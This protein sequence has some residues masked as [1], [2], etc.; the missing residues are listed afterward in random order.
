MMQGENRPESRLDDVCDASD[1]ISDKASDR[2]RDK[3]SDKAR[4]RQDFSR[5]ITR[6]EG[7]RTHPYLDD[8]G[9]ITIGVGR[10]LSDRGLARD[11]ILLLLGNDMTLAQR[12]CEAQYGVAFACAD[13][14]RQLAL[15]S[16]AFNLGAPR[17]G[18]FR[19][20][21]AAIRS[22]DWHLA[23]HEAL[24]SRWASQVGKRADEIADMLR[25]PEP[26]A[27]RRR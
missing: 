3:A 23:A 25:S 16:M 11:E 21:H 4:N 2:A 1:K 18:G 6:H 8:V 22:G 14:R 12:I 20:M 9:K 13:R 26:T 7:W 15:M 5:L 10:N 27:K 24:N 19:R 17:L